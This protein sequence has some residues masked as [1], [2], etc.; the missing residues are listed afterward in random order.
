MAHGGGAS[1]G[2]P[3]PMRTSDAHEHTQRRW[4]ESYHDATVA[5]AGLDG[6]VHPGGGVHSSRL[7]TG[8]GLLL[9]W[10]EIVTLRA[11]ECSPQ[12]L[13]AAAALLLLEPPLNISCSCS[14]KFFFDST[15]SPTKGGGAGGVRRSPRSYHDDTGLDGG[16]HPGGGVHSSRLGTG[17]GL[18]LGWLEIVTLRTTPL[19]PHVFFFAAARFGAGD[20]GAD[21]GA[22]AFGAG[23]G[24]DD[25]FCCDTA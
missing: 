5:A 17:A 12:S 1:P 13:G 19:S 23:G 15:F 9:G 10:L 25:D 14:K 16:V 3:V 6:G 22:A 18:L 11:F 8:A 24:D 21:A 4:P 20:G 2:L 7:G